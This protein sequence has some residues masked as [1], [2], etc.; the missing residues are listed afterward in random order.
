MLSLPFPAPSFFSGVNIFSAGKFRMSP[1]HVK[2]VAKIF[3]DCIE[4]NHSFK[5]VYELGGKYLPGMKL[6]QYFECIQ[7]TKAYCTSSS[8]CCIYDGLLLDRF[9]WF[10]IS[11]DQITMLLEGNTCE[12]AQIFKRYNIKPIA[13]KSENLS[14]LL[15]GKK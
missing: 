7:Q 12:S 3:V 14:Y 9:S 10:P 15:N 8:D 11:R 1:V 5:K 6:Y 13:F 4:N 2:D